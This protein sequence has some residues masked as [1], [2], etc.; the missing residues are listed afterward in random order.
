[1]GRRPF[2]GSLYLRR[3][4]VHDHGVSR[5]DRVDN[6]SSDVVAA[7]AAGVGIDGGGVCLTQVLVC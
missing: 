2:Q 3:F 6:P 7:L 4:D 5:S 1:M